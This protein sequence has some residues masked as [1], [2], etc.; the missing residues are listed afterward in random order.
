MTRE[1][2]RPQWKYGKFPQVHRANISS[3][4]SQEAWGF[5][6]VI[7]LDY[8]LMSPRILFGFFLVPLWAA[9]GAENVDGLNQASGVNQTVEE[10][11]GARHAGMA[12]SFAG[13]QRDADAVANAPAAMN[14]VDDFTFSTAHAEKFGEAKFDNFAF[15][16]PFETHSTLGLGL[17]RYGV[18]G[19]EL[20]PDGASSLQS[21]APE[22][23]SVADYLLVA[24]FARRWGD[25]DFGFDF[26]LLYRQ[27]DQHG[28]GMRGD[29][30][31]QYTWN[32]YLRFSTVV[33]GLIPS[34]AAWE[35]GYQEYEATDIYLGV[36]GRF[37]TPYFYGSVQVA[38]QSEG[39]FQAQGKS[40]ETLKGS[41]IYESP[42]DILSTLNLGL[43]YLFDFG[44]SCRFGLQELNA[45]K[46]FTS[47]STF[48]VG[49]AWKKTIGVDYSFTPHP[50]LLSTHRISLQLTPV[51]PKFNGRNFRRGPIEV[52]EN[53]GKA[54]HAPTAV[55]AEI[56]HPS[57]EKEILEQEPGELE[58]N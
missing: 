50:D 23:F 6:D 35:S 48:G 19:V 47:L 40:A 45:S 27:L 36:A 29:A 32:D 41:R 12:I 37:P 55:E 52:H 54:E 57:D 14:D 21:Q 43:E 4:L 5:P 53:S 56:P 10:G 38:A 25:L 39:L 46:D 51:F 20:R 1:T 30:M 17:A 26:N 33:K 15:L 58:E 31:A 7:L 49:Y 9:F 28:I 44:L 34:S 42:N 2:E 16:F 8:P 18:S 3:K 22:V 11:F 24:A 13:F